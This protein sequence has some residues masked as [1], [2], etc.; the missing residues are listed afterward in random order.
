MAV[1]HCKKEHWFHE[2]VGG[3]ND[4]NTVKR[5]MIMTDQDSF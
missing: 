3:H 2:N 4:G 5:N 1:R